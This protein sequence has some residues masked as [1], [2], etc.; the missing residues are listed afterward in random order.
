MYFALSHNYFLRGCVWFALPLNPFMSA[1]RLLELRIERSS[2]TTVW[3]RAFQCTVVQEQ[4]STQ[5][6]QT[7]ESFGLDCY[8]YFPQGPLTSRSSA[9]PLCA[10]WPRL[11]RILFYGTLTSRDYLRCRPPLVSML[12]PPY[13]CPFPPLI[14]FVCHVRSVLRSSVFF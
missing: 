14:V 2:C 1:Y 7:Y 4:R 3:S 9:R 10:W 13:P 5:P 11:V 12:I 6:D 8:Q